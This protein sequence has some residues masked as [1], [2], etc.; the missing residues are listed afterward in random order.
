MDKK[1]LAVGIL[2]FFS[3]CDLAWWGICCKYPE[4]A[5]RGVRIVKAI[6]SFSFGIA[7][8]FAV[9]WQLVP[10]TWGIVFAVIWLGITCWHVIEI[11]DKSRD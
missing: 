2:F 7:W 9:E 5:G 4:F 6:S 1:Q 10:P 11:L 8:Y 3:L